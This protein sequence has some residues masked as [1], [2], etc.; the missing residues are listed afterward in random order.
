METV[1]EE[2]SLVEV[3]STEGGSSAYEGDVSLACSLGSE[4]EEDEREGE[5]ETRPLSRLLDLTEVESKEPSVL[6]TAPAGQ[7][8]GLSSEVSNIKADTT[9]G[10]RAGK[11]RRSS[12]EARRTYA[13]SSSPGVRR[14]VPVR[15]SKRTPGFVTDPKQEAELIQARSK[16]TQLELEVASLQRAAKRARI[17]EEEADDRLK[18]ELS[19]QIESL[20]KVCVA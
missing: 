8:I 14:H 18:L 15:G 10:R 16:V 2:L 1:D 20:H 5:G 17:D 12:A 11:P 3:D 13:G 4:A 7:K 19:D 9:S 6:S